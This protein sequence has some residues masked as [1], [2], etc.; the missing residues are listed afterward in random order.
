M[1][2]NIPSHYVFDRFSFENL[3]VHNIV[4]EYF[5]YDKVKHAHSPLIASFED[6]EI[7]VIS[8]PHKPKIS[9]GLLAINSIENI[10][11]YQEGDIVFVRCKF[12]F[13]NRHRRSKINDKYIVSDYTLDKARDEFKSKTGLEDILY[14][15][16]HYSDRPRIERAPYILEKKFPISN[17][18]IIYGKMVI[19]NRELFLKSLYHG[20]GSRRSYG[21]GLLFIEHCNKK[22][23]KNK[24]AALKM[25]IE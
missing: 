1:K 14:D 11:N 13:C 12:T 22:G 9:R 16:T 19:D 15:K 3:S 5:D 18:F 8:S 6:D 4:R 10:E 24:Y 2:N 23:E 25:G 21:F 7:F 20:I 17:I